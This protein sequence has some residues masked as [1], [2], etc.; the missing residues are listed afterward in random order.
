MELEKRDALLSLSLATFCFLN[1]WA[2][3]SS[4]T[5]YYYRKLPPAAT[6]IWATAANTLLL[7]IAIWLGIAWVKRSKSP[8]IRYIGYVCF[9]ALLI[10]AVDSLQVHVVDFNIEGRLTRRV[11]WEVRALAAAV[12]LGVVL[13]AAVYARFLARPAANLMI[14]LSPLFPLVAVQ[15]V[16][17]HWKRPPDAHFADAVATR[18]ASPAKATRMLWLMF[19]EWDQRISFENRPS[20][21]AL[22]EIDRFRKEALSANRFSGGWYGT[23]NAVPSM[24]TGHRVTQS[25]EAGPR[26][27]AVRW[28]GGN[29]PSRWS[30]RPSFFQ[31]LREQGWSVGL[32]GWY[33]P[34]CRVIGS[35]I[36][37]CRWEAGASIYDRPEYSQDLTLAESMGVIAE[38]Q[39][40]KPVGLSWA[41]LSRKDVRQRR[42]Q[43]R[44]YQSIYNEAMKMLGNV[45]FLMVHLPVPHPF[46]IYK[47]QSG[48]LGGFPNAT[49]VDNLA[50]TDRTL[51]DFRSALTQQGQWDDVTVILSSDHSLRMA[52]WAE[53]TGWSDAERQ[54]FGTTRARWVPFMIK[55]PAKQP[56]AIYDERFSILLMHDLI[57]AL[58]R[59]EIRTNDE[60]R[61][62]LDRNKSRFPI[63]GSKP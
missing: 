1:P 47:R 52:Y 55:L 9:F 25:R 17:T 37:I 26:D 48:E 19:D 8:T 10:A 32:S 46:G 13:L 16:W 21:F 27:L 60:L 24:L 4:S 6:T 41:N 43:A 56:A 45:D 39:L 20:G 40:L 42:L 44:E 35:Q 7:T 38:R 30:A 34:Y 11:G 61:S 12:V 53:S 2:E 57:I 54:A 59:Q 49:Y 31:I 50:L 23:R 62:W 15:A 5:H 28:D 29:E 22:P 58:A 18:R 51:K 33:H 63:P 3:L 36:D 14:A